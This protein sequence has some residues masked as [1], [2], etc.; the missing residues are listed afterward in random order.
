MSHTLREGRHTAIS[1][2]WGKGGG[3]EEAPTGQ[4]FPG[5]FP[6]SPDGLVVGP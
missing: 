5:T 4:Q 2:K 6:T 3:Y 1:N